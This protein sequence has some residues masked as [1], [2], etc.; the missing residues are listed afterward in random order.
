MNQQIVSQQSKPNEEA[1]TAKSYTE[2]IYNSQ[3]ELKY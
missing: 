1:Q 3:Y 2:V